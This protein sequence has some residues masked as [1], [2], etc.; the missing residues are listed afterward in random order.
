MGGYSGNNHKT[1]DKSLSDVM[2]Y[3]FM[4]YCKRCLSA[5][6]ITVVEICGG[7]EYGAPEALQRVLEEAE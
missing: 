7:N 6:K 4:A 1:F 3:T 5:L 2:L